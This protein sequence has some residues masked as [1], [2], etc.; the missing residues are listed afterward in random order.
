MRFSGF[1][2]IGLGLAAAPIQ[3]SCTIARDV[4]FTRP[5]YK[6]RPYLLRS[7]PTGSQSGSTVLPM[8]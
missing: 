8:N 1:V 7:D 5:S 2:V 6:V 3:A 4:R